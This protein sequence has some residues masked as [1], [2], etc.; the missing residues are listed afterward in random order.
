MTSALSRLRALEQRFDGPIPQRL[1]DAALHTPEQRRRH[2]IQRA[3]RT[4]A[5]CQHVLDQ[6][7]SGERR[8]VGDDVGLYTRWRNEW[9]AFRHA[10]E[11]SEG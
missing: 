5:E 11:R 9:I 10:L 1:I 6:M 2:M 3:E 7:A 4:I 8:I